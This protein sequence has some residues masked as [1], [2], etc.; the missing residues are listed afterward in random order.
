MHIFKI[1]YRKVKNGQGKR[2]PER[3]NME[4]SKQEKKKSKKGKVHLSLT[5]A[6][7]PICDSL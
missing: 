6:A 5:V 7:Q 4:K 1:K 2:K 3:K